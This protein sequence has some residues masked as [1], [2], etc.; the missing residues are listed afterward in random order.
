MCFFYNSASSNEQMG[1]GMFAHNFSYCS[2]Y[3]L[4]IHETERQCADVWQVVEYNKLGK[5]I[6]LKNKKFLLNVTVFV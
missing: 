3:R 6:K 2:M 5:I 1:Q 4:N